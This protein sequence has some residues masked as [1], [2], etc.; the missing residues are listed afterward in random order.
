MLEILQF[1]FSSFWIWVGTFFL[2]VAIGASL[3]GLVKIVIN[4]KK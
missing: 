4:R 2:V 1:T 3:G